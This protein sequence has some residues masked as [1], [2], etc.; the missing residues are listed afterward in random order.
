MPKRD[1]RSARRGP[2]KREWDNCIA[3]TRLR[4]DGEICGVEAT[5]ETIG[6]AVCRGGL[7]FG[8]ERPDNRD[9]AYRSIGKTFEEKNRKV[10]EK[11]SIDRLAG[12][13]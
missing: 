1:N 9:H 11:A 5:R 4:C 12:P 2:H 8:T 6:V 7:G 3:R 10:E 13:R